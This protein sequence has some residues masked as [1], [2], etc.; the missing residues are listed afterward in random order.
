ME[1]ETLSAIYLSVGHYNQPRTSIIQP[2]Q[3][4]TLFYWACSP[5][6]LAN[7]NTNIH[8]HLRGMKSVSSVAFL[9]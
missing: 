8:T 3:S 2:G 6:V 5:C 1:M 7:T 4:I 9:L